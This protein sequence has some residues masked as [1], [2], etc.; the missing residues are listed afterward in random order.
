MRAVMFIL[1]G[2]AA[3]FV[4]ALLAFIVYIFKTPVDRER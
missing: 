1:G 4:I 3:I 2:F